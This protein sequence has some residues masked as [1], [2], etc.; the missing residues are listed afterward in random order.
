MVGV[1]FEKFHFGHLIPL[2]AKGVVLVFSVSGG[3]I[4]GLFIDLSIHFQ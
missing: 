1:I 2:L 3:V 4:N